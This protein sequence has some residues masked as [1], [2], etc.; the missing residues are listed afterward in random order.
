[1]PQGSITS[2]YSERHISVSTE[3]EL[4]VYSMRTVSEDYGIIGRFQLTLPSHSGRDPISQLQ[5]DLMVCQ[6]MLCYDCHF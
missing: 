2:L 3:R 6:C 4:F 1:M 5:S